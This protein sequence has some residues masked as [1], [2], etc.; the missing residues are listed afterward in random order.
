MRNQPEQFARASVF[1]ISIVIL[2]TTASNSGIMLNESYYIHHTNNLQQ[3]FG[4]LVF[5]SA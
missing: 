1:A 5:V 4:L 3:W 2:L